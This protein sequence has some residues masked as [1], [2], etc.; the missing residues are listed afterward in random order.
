MGI[1][2][3][4]RK[5]GRKIDVFSPKKGTTTQTSTSTPFFNKELGAAV[6]DATNLYSSQNPT[7][8]GFGAETQGAL[9]E[10]QGYNPGASLSAQQQLMATLGGD[11]LNSNPYLDQTF[12]RGADAINQR[13][14][15]DFARAGALNTGALVGSTGSAYTNLANDIY[16]GNYQ[17][18]RARMMQAAGMAPGIDQGAMMGIGNRLQAGGMIDKEADARANFGYDS[19]WDEISR[20]LGVIQNANDAYGTVEG[21]TPYSRNR[22]SGILGGALGGAQAGAM[23]GPLGAGLGALGGGVLGGS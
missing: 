16:G 10:L 7:Y 22:L 6:G 21:K 4:L 5:I 1:G 14:Q 18:E 15:S 19:G 13:L 20:Y 8:T 23:F 17:S 9:D 11:Y 2:S 12:N 3:D